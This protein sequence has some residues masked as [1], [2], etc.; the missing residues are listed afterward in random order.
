MYTI[1]LNNKTAVI[2]GIANQRSIAWSITKQLA[3]AGANIIA[4]YQNDRVKGPVEK[5]LSQLDKSHM[6]EC[7]VSKEENVHEAFENKSNQCR[8]IDTLVHSIAYADRNDLGGKFLK[9][10]REGF[11]TALDISAYSLVSI[12]RNATPLMTAGG[13]IITMSFMAAEKVFPGYN[14]MSTAKAALENEVRQLANDLGP[15]DI[16]VNAISAGPL[17]TLSSRVISGYRDMKKAHSDRAPMKRNI[18]H[19]EVASTALYLCSDMSSGVTGEIVHVDTGYHVM[20][21]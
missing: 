2:F 6:V 20:G 4:V 10:S 21:I 13:T 18:T 9:T 8:S 12:V 3:A 16:R 5:L 11:M 7:D 19:S 15:D 14:V 1:D 17:D